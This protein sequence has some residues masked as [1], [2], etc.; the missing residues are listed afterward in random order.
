MSK[1]FWKVYGVWLLL[2][3]VVCV[4]FYSL[5]EGSSQSWVGTGF[6]G[7]LSCE[8]ALLERSVE[9]V[10]LQCAVYQ[11][12][13][14]TY[15]IYVVEQY[16]DVRGNIGFDYAFRDMQRLGDLSKSIGYCPSN[17]SS[18]VAKYKLGACAKDVVVCPVVNNS[19]V[20][21]PLSENKGGVPVLFWFIVLGIVIVAIFLISRRR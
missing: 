5:S 13:L 8:K 6:D 15:G 17:P 19:V 20:S 1:G 2:L 4:V 16:S 3:V 21:P 9:P 14:G 18:L 11:G 7:E 12:K 10:S